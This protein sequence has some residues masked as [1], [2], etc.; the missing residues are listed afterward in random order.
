MIPPR[1]TAAD[2][3]HLATD[4]EH[5]HRRAAK[6]RAILAGFSNEA[7]GIHRS[8]DELA[9]LADVFARPDIRDANFLAWYQ[10]RRQATLRPRIAS[11]KQNED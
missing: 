8:T 11:R 1:I 9:Q 3:A 4:I 10:I 7:S 2:I 5:L 6:G